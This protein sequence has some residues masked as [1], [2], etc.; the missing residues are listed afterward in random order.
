MAILD[1][2]LVFLTKSVFAKEKMPK[3]LQISLN[4]LFL[5]QKELRPSRILLAKNFV[6]IYLF[7][8][9]VRFIWCLNE[10]LLVKFVLKKKASIHIQAHSHRGACQLFGLR[11]Y[12]Q[13]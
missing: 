2:F 1:Q 6:I 12:S 3:N 10:S 9:A 7:V 11:V 8:F 5:E 4:Y 13:L